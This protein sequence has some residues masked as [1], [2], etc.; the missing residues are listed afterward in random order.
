MSNGKTTTNEII[1]L[2]EESPDW[3]GD[4]DQDMEE[5]P[6]EAVV[7][8]SASSGACGPAPIEREVG[9]AYS[10]APLLQSYNKDAR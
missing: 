9:G 6:E 1:N 2:T 8:T 3:G 7:D 5:A 4:E 10:A